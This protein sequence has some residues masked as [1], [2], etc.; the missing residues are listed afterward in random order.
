[1]NVF[2]QSPSPF[3]LYYIQCQW[4][5][6]QHSIP[7]LN[8]LPLHRITSS[9]KNKNTIFHNF[10]PVRSVR[11]YCQANN[12]L[13]LIVFHDALLA[14]LLFWTNVLFLLKPLIMKKGTTQRTTY[15][16]RHYQSHGY[17]IMTQ[18]GKLCSF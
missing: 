13:P 14:L 3:S 10:F 16:L 6:I 18:G 9:K 17:V 5:H 15:F 8:H 11:L 1:M 4:V 7:T 12:T 2:P